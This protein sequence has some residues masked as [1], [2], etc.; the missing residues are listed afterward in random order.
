MCVFHQD[1]NFFSY[2]FYFVH[3]E[4]ELYYNQLICSQ[5]EVSV[6]EINLIPNEDTSY[7][8]VEVLIPLKNLR[9]YSTSLSTIFQKKCVIRV[10]RISISQYYK[11]NVI[12]KS[13]KYHCSL[14]GRDFKN[15]WILK[16]HI[17]NHS[18]DKP[19]TC[20]ICSKQ[21][22]RNYSLTVHKRSHTGEKPF[23][24]IYCYKTYK[25]KDELERHELYHTS[26][27]PMCKI[28][29]KIFASHQIAKRHELEFHSNKQKYK[30]G[31]CNKKFTRQHAL[32][33]HSETH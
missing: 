26:N 25:R 18:G 19:Y 1:Q 29:N 23:T 22:T 13:G 12:S 17:K 15:K 30:C 20:S 4:P 11:N 5:N 31:I 9:K 28:C 27:K 2:Y 24:C 16:R 8:K 14:C 32:N 10:K 6:E 33:K 21:F 3:I 7:E